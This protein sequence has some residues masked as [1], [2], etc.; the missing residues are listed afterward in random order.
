M[1]FLILGFIYTQTSTS[2]T[3]VGSTDQIKT[4]STNSSE[5][6]QQGEQST[7][8]NNSDLDEE[9][10]SVLEDPTKQ[11][12]ENWME[13]VTTGNNQYL[14]SDFGGISQLE[15]NVNNNSPYKL[16]EVIVLVSYIKVNGDIFK[17]ETL[18]FSDIEPNTQVTLSAPDSPRGMRIEHSIM[19]LKSSE[20][21]V[22]FP[23]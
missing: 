7:I 15:I 1:R 20:M 23:H 6:S 17:N 14:Y 10:M 5:N 8:P 11:Y 13:Y 19:N 18:S 9:V 21:G 3:E 4:N 12:R 2:K 16:V 22:H